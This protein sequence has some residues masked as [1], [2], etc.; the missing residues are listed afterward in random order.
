M[1]AASI[2]ITALTMTES[3]EGFDFDISDIL[4]LVRERDLFTDMALEQ[5]MNATCNILGV[6]FLESKFIIGSKYV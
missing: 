3:D 5:F 1:N 6:Q 4:T 2:L